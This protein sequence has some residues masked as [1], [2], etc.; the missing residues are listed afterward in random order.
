MLWLVFEATNYAAVRPSSRPRWLGG[1][2]MDHEWVDTPEDPNNFLRLSAAAPAA[3][4]L[5]A[6]RSSPF[7]PVELRASGAP[8]FRKRGEAEEWTWMQKIEMVSLYVLH[9]G[10]VRDARG[11]T[12][13]SCA[14]I[15]GRI[16]AQGIRFAGDSS[17][18]DPLGSDAISAPREATWSCVRRCW[19]TRILGCRRRQLRRLR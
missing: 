8:A 10:V 15:W 3:R 19:T 17:S 9:P 7:A 6:A 18:V 4:A 5:P 16:G 12:P 2:R 13:F 11:L 14:R 1:S